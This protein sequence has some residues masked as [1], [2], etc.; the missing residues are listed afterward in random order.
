MD[1]KQIITCL[2]IG[3]MSFSMAD[4]TFATAPAEGVEAAK[5][6][7]VV[8]RDIA[9]ELIK[10]MKDG[11]LVIPE[12]YTVIT[13]SA[14]ALQNGIKK[15]NLSNI[16]TIEN[17]AFQLCMDLEKIDF[18]NVQTIGTYAFDGCSK[19]NEINF[20]NVHTIG[21]RA[22]KNCKEL[23]TIDLKNV[24]TIE[25]GAFDCCT[26]LNK[27]NLG[28]V[29][30]IDISAF[31]GCE[32]L[33]S[34]T[35]P[36]S[37]ISIGISAFQNCTGLTKI[38]FGNVKS[39][40]IL[41]FTGCTS[42]ESITIPD[43]VTSIGNGA[44]AMCMNLKSV[45]VYNERIKKLVI[46][47]NSLIN[48]NIIHIIQENEE[49]ETAKQGK[50]VTYIVGS[51]LEQE[52]KDGE[53]IIPEEYTAINDYAFFRKGDIKKI[54]FGNVQ[55]I[56]SGVFQGCTSLNKIDFKNVQSIGEFAFEGCT[57]LNKIDFK[58]VQSIGTLAFDEC[59][60][61]TEIDFKNVQS[62]GEFAFVGCTSL[63]SITI[64]DS[65][66]SIG[67]GAFFKCTNLK[68]VNVYSERVKQLVIASGSVIDKKKIHVIQEN[69]DD[70]SS[71]SDNDIL[72][73]ISVLETRIQSLVGVDIEKV[74][75]VLDLHDTNIFD[76][77]NE[78][79]EGSKSADA[80]RRARRDNRNN[81]SDIELT[82]GDQ[83]AFND[84]AFYGKSK[85]AY[86]AFLIEQLG[87]LT[88]EAKKRGL[89]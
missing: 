72:K 11:E 20:S 32:S 34:I 51:D 18:K 64:P 76:E 19:L 4:N 60:R 14:F 56:G 80:K 47:S 30:T 40:G 46:A 1:L 61:L 87:E 12:E 84:A 71:L 3:M 5:Q 41:A 89:K 44:F 74:D 65:V 27:I 33:E 7:K 36:D 58:N 39:I 75:P 49:V 8:T 21:E 15:I 59:T 43:S 77:E 16:Q 50:V 48:K 73:Q 35:I 42:L 25:L 63:E 6:G 57:S 82:K 67:D 37:V 38:D 17:G 88:A 26:N 22:F 29:K 28:N 54:D 23:K 31:Y 53:L 45:N 70:V 68:S 85:K 9:K 52:M 2:S 78:F 13:K 81:A 62:I 83:K 66:T 10:N 24:Q 86:K 55:S 79:I 69:A